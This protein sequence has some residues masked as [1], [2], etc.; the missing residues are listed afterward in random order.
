MQAANMAFNEAVDVREEA[1]RIVI[2]PVRL[3]EYR[4][5]DLLAQITPENLH[6]EVEFG[7]PIGK[8]AW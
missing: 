7:H 5:D 8:E 4:L 2:E 3:T 6:G 1:G